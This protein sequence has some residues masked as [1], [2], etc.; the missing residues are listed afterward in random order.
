VNLRKSAYILIFVVASLLYANESISCENGSRP[1][2]RKL[3]LVA[4]YWE[5]YTGEG[6]KRYG[7]ATDFVVKNLRALGIDVQI[8][9]APWARAYKMVKEG[10][11]DG[12]VAVWHT[13]ERERDI[14]FSKPY[15]TST[16]VLLKKKGNSIEYKDLSSLRQLTL[17]LGRG[18]DYHDD[19]AK[20]T[21]VNNLYYTRIE[22]AVEMLRRGRV[23]AVLD[24]KKVIEF[25]LNRNKDQIDFQELEF[26]SG[27]V[28][29]LPLHFGI[30]NKYPGARYIINDFNKC[31]SDD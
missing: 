19:L 26:V 3:T 11:A 7:I 15:F 28:F 30:S 17:A 13:D 2:F 24:D 9:I 20:Y 8:K 18:Y 25:Y 10:K 27:S 31:L 23:D 29:E 5:P 22:T 16:V 6:I 4:N 14:V 21:N 12:I 1:L